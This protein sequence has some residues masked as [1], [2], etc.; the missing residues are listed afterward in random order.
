MEHYICCLHLLLSIT[1]TLF[2]RFVLDHIGTGAAGYQRAITVNA[3][4]KELRVSRRGLIPVNREKAV[5]VARF[6]GFLG[7]EAVSVL[8][9][10]DALVD[11][12]TSTS[13]KETDAYIKA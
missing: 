3:I 9:R 1:K 6:G 7:A 2:Q 11:A 10:F 5:K 13:K 4:L 12:A 8:S